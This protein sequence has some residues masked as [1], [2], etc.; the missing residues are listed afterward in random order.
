MQFAAGDEVLSRC[1]D[2]STLDN[3]KPS[4]HSRLNQADAIRSVIYLH[5]VIVF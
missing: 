5:F 3:M 2:S 1:F 4:N